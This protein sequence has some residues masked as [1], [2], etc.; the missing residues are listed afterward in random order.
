MVDVVARTLYSPERDAAVALGV[1]DA[2]ASV[3]GW[4]RLETF[5]PARWGSNAV[6][7]GQARP[8]SRDRRPGGA[9][10]AGLARR[11]H[12]AALHHRSPRGRARR[13]RPGRRGRPARAAAPPRGEARGRP[14]AH[15]AR[16]GAHLPVARRADLRRHRLPGPPRRRA[17]AHRDRD[18]RGDVLHLVRAGRRAARLARR[19]PGRGRGADQPV[20]RRGRVPRRPAARRLRRGAVARPRR[21]GRR[22]HAAR[23]LPAPRPLRGRQSGP[24]CRTCATSP[25]PC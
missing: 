17:A 12:A 1:A 18:R 8:R 10:A 21:A 7:R 25:W 9:A 20:D 15:A 23:R 16:R 4:S 5:Q 14:R 3:T 24:A 6:G 11:P 13:P 22:A 19:A 2:Q